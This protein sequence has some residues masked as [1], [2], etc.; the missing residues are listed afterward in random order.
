[1][2]CIEGED[3]SNL[4]VRKGGSSEHKREGEWIRQTTGTWA[5]SVHIEPK[6]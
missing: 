5:D 2:K 3:H 6:W 1:V 4:I